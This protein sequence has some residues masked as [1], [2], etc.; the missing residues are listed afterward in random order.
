MSRRKRL[1]RQ[2]RN[3]RRRQQ[4]EWQPLHLAK[5]IAS[6]LATIAR[7]RKKTPFW[8][9]PPPA[10]TTPTTEHWRLD[11]LCVIC[12][13]S[14]LLALLHL[15]YGRLRSHLTL[16]AVYLC[17]YLSLRCHVCSLFLSSFWCWPAACAAS[18]QQGGGST[19]THCLYFLCF[20]L[21]S[22]HTSLSFERESLET[23]LLFSDS[24]GSEVG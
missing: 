1:S 10:T 7:K 12:A 19:R 15:R 14:G 5:L 13:V 16:R 24:G 18:C 20:L 3:R 22:S 11:M 8:L 6:A 17:F 9:L 21:F 2:S 4:P 23:I